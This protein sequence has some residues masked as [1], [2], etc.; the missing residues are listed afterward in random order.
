M[1]IIQP[2]LHA[3]FSR[4]ESDRIIYIAFSGGM[5]STVLLHASNELAKQQQRTLRAIHVDHQMQSVAAA[6]AQHCQQVCQQL[7]VQ[8]TICQVNVDEYAHLGP[9]GAARA[10]RQ[11]AFSQC[12][13]TDA[14][15]FTAH[16][17]DDQVETILLRL[18]RSAGVKGMVGC[19]EQRRLGVG[20]LQRP[21]LMIRRQQIEQY[22]RQHELSY[23]TDPSND[24]LAFDRNYVRHKLMPA[25]VAR[26]PHVGEAV[27]RSSQ[28]QSEASQ[29]L[30][31]LARQ[32]LADST[33]NPLPVAQ[34]PQHDQ[35]SLKNALRWWIE[36][37]GLAAPTMTVL[38]EII[39]QLL[40]AH[41]DATACV[42]WQDNEIRKYRDQIY[43]QSCLSEHDSSL[44][45]EW[46]LATDLA[47][48]SLDM[49]LTRS[50]LSQAGLSLAQLEQ[51]QVRFR[52]GGESLRPRGRGCQKELKTLFQEAAVPPWLRERIP[53][54]YHQQQLI[55]VFGHWIHEGY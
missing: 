52:Q 49:V 53:L 46:D 41:A 47:I 25:I 30:D 9:E 19:L 13:Q 15:I 23:F 7:D 5:D 20:E 50:M 34:L 26:W 17:A 29:L 55:Y 31:R 16:H 40:P 28:W 35:A 32:D 22:A 14:V 51:V 6:M 39:Q 36:Q 3:A 18:F 1:T 54:I 38:Q 4:I 10:A 24:S 2:A 37:Q 48:P 42:C 12:L 33:A 43:A 44:C 11:Q 21:L 45:L 8:L 27:T